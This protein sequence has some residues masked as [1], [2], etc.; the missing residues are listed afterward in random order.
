MTEYGNLLT[1]AT[2]RGAAHMVPYSQPSRALHL[3]SSFVRGRRLPNT[4]H[5]SIDD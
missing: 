3:F 2:V 1:F 5:S 4:T